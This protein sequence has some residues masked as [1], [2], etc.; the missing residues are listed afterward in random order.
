M[1]VPTMLIYAIAVLQ[2]KFAAPDKGYHENRTSVGFPDDGST[3]EP[4]GEHGLTH[5]DP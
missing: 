1:V 3:R 4:K 5:T 2:P